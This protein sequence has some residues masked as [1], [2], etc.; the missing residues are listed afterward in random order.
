MN[1]ASPLQ[2]LH[3]ERD[4][5]RHRHTQTH[6][7]T[8][9]HTHTHTHT[10]MQIYSHTYEDAI[11]STRKEPLRLPQIIIIT[12]Q[13]ICTRLGGELRLSSHVRT[14]VRARTHAHTHTLIHVRISKTC[15]RITFKTCVNAHIDRQGHVE[16]KGFS[17][18]HQQVRSNAEHCARLYMNVCVLMCLCVF[19]C[20]FACM[21]VII[22]SICIMIY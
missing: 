17:W 14:R 15:V 3:S 1:C 5:D 2:S 10:H 19:V 20:L 22:F 6:T 9:T 11:V 4:I 21:H 12:K 8:N 13:H 7:Q 16:E 18:L